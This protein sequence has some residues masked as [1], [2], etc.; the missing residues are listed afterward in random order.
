MGPSKACMSAYLIAVL[1]LVAGAR[2]AAAFNYADALD[3]AV[4]FFE[5][6]RSG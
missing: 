6:Q 2:S 1:C 4:L 3:K 5:A